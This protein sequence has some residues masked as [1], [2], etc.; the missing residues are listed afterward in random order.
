MVYMSL[1]VNQDIVAKIICAA[2]PD[3]S[4]NGVSG[5][6]AKLPPKRYV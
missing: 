2:G 1:F 5:V 6:P 4:M 3:F